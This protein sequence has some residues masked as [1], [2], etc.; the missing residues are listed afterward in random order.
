MK[1]LYS[2]KSDDTNILYN[3]KLVPSRSFSSRPLIS[4]TDHDHDEERQQKKKQTTSN[5]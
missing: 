5:M 3:I 1:A 4:T 2:S